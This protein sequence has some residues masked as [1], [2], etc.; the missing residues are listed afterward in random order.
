MTRLL[1]YAPA[2]ETLRKTTGVV[3][4]V[5]VP[6]TTDV[7][8]AQ[9]MIVETAGAFAGVVGDPARVCLNVDGSPG[10]LA[11]A[12]EAAARLGVRVTH[13]DVNRGKF[14][15]LRRGMTLLLEDPA[16][17]CLA[18]ADQD[19]DHFAN[20]LVNLVRAA[21]YT[22]ET[23][24][25]SA[26]VVIGQRLSRH[27]PM[28]LLRAELEELAD[29]VLLEALRYHAAVAGRPLRLEYATVQGEF[30]DFHSGYKLLTRP[31]AEAVFRPEPQ[32]AGLGAEAMSRHAVE[33]V[34]TVEALLSGALL[35]LVRRSTFDEQPVTAFGLLNRRRMTADMIL[36][37]CRRLGAPAAFVRQ[38]MDNCLPA[39]PLGTLAPQGR[40]ELL[41]VR[42][43]VLENYGAEKADNRLLRPRFL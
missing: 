39:L 8:F 27:H 2:L 10:G 34:M 26:V 25:V 5:F 12:R 16:V 29:R 37:P 24:G 21:R 15:A 20:E 22:A 42:R 18:A 35:A 38:W 4:P 33:A 13:D 14:F 40:E 11:A 9:Q 32:D 30:P 3:I 31:A 17:T 6:P 19:G 23:S 36:W 1:D 43:M 7:S 28:G 41:D